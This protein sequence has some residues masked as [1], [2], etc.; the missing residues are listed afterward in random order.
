MAT[1]TSCT[2]GQVTTQHR[3]EANSSTVN[4]SARFD[5][6]FK[7]KAGNR[8]PKSQMTGRGRSRRL[9]Y[10]FTVQTDIDSDRTN[11]APAPSGQGQT[12]LEGSNCGSVRQ[13]SKEIIDTSGVKSVG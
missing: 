1:M 2:F 8:A 12:Q 13:K 9:V 11:R 4:A 10:V 7:S 3:V 5:G 6:C